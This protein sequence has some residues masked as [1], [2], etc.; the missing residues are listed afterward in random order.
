MWGWGEPP[1]N[2][3]VERLCIKLGGSARCSLPPFLGIR[4]WVETDW[5]KGG[6]ES[7]KCRRNKDS[8]KWRWDFGCCNSSG[9]QVASYRTHVSGKGTSRN[10]GPVLGPRFGKG[11]LDFS[12]RVDGLF[13][14]EAGVISAN[15]L[16]CLLIFMWHPQ[17]TEQPSEDGW[18]FSG[19]ISSADSR[20]PWHR[21][22]QAL[23]LSAG[24]CSVSPALFFFLETPGQLE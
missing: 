6:L 19:H 12:T 20:A 17:E 16:H 23:A 15:Q 3:K 21:G 24:L 11:S 14:Q 18:L 8:E 4:Q 1:E 5:R 9:F 2:Y 7:G 10:Q 13:S 22:S